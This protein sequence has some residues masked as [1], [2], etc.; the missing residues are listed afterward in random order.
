MGGLISSYFVENKVKM[1]LCNAIT[2]SNTSEIKRIM[3][4][5]KESSSSSSFATPLN[6]I[7]QMCYYSKEADDGSGVDLLNDQIDQKGNTPLLLSIETG[8]LESFKFL[9]IQLN[10]D[11][12]ICNYETGYSPLHM[13][14]KVK[15]NANLNYKTSSRTNSQKSSSFSKTALISPQSPVALDKPFISNIQPENETQSKTTSSF[16]EEALR[17]M[18]YLLVDKGAMLNKTIQI[19]ISS[20]WDHLSVI[21]FTP[22]MLAVYTLNFIVAEEL[23]NLGCDCNFQEENQN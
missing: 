12:N 18:V 9:L 20:D 14:A 10:A 6:F 23:L 7:K 2:T 19:D 8:Q 4:T 17:E 15:C 22:L 21:F 13:L 1:A 16:N 5:A 3:S 11:P